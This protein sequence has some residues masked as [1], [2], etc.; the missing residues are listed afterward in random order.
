MSTDQT[1]S[2]ILP[3]KQNLTLP[4]ILSLA[5][6]VLM[7]GASI[8][9]L[10]YRETIYPTDEL[11][12]M[13]MPNDVINLV[14]G[15]P[16]LLVS[17]WLA[18]RG[19]LIGLLLWPGALVYAFY[20]YL[21]YIFVVPLNLSYLLGLILVTLCAYTL[22][23]MV[24]SIDTAAVQAQLTGKVP[25]KLAGG[26]TAAF[27]ILFAGR[28]IAMVGGAQVNQTPID[29]I[30]LAVMVADFVISPAMVI[31]GVLL[32]QR[33]ALGYAAGLGLLFQAS[34]LFIGLIAFLL[35]Q[36]VLTDAP[37]SLT[38]VL[39]VAVMGLVCFVPF[40]LFVR[41]VTTSSS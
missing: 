8:I 17:M 20:N 15:V 11:L 26:I 32:W 18:R 34:M 10:G 3:I 13:I 39:V 36:P 37:F 24:A 30:D 5:I 40:G 19:K 9:G 2:P 29:S 23:A 4:Y 33:K 35:I 21:A 22:I 12:E 27:G 25:E 7:T 31:G 16:I 6:T 28:V 38:D 41:G 14:V 1:Y